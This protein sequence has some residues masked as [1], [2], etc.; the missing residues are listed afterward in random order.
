MP[1]NKKFFE[2]PAGT[3]NFS[4]VNTRRKIFNF[5]KSSFNFLANFRRRRKLW[6][7]EPVVTNHAI[8]IG[9]SNGTIFEG[10]DIGQRFLRL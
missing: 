5:L 9:I 7:A 8:F 4:G 2:G 1:I 3:A 10:S 6:V